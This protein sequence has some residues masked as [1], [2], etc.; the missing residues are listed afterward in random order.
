MKLI[1]ACI[2]AMSL[3][4][5]LEAGCDRIAIAGDVRMKASEVR[6]L[7]IVLIPTVNTYEVT[8][9]TGGTFTK[10]VNVFERLLDA[11]LSDPHWGWKKGKSWNCNHKRLAGRLDCELVCAKLGSW[12][13]AMALHT[14]TIQYAYM[15]TMLVQERNMYID[16]AYFLHAHPQKCR[17]GD[18]CSLIVACSSEEEFFKLLGLPY[19]EPQDRTEAVLWNLIRESKPH[20]GRMAW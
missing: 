20:Y 6:N 5:D 13:G 12:G 4:G 11:K 10:S 3:L 17:A 14:G 16:E 19:I 7:D 2:L 8:G 18:K 9:L 1:D 15:L